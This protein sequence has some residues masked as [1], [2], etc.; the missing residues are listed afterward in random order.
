MGG[1]PIGGRGPVAEG[2]VGWV[3]GLGLMV[4]AARLIGTRTERKATDG[5]DDRV[6]R[7]G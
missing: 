6:D 2:F 7:Q 3:I 5:H 4:F 1:F